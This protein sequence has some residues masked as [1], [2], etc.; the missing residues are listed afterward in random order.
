MQPRRSRAAV[1][2]FST[3]GMDKQRVAV[4][5]DEIERAKR[6]QPCREIGH[7]FEP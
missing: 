4:R 7:D 2:L 1:V 5:I 3:V 6:S